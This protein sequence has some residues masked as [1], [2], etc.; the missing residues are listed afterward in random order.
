LGNPHFARKRRPLSAGQN[1]AARGHE[2]DAQTER[3]QMRRLAAQNFGMRMRRWPFGILDRPEKAGRRIAVQ[4]VG[5]QI[6][7]GAELVWLLFRF[8]AVRQARA[9]LSKSLFGT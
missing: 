4:S 5:T 7:V 1:A 8:L 2:I 6:F 3:M 9:T